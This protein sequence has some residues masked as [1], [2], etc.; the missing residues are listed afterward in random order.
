MNNITLEILQPYLD[1]GYKVIAVVEGKNPRMPANGFYESPNTVAYVDMIVNDPSITGFGIA[2][3]P[4]GTVFLDFDDMD[5]YQKSMK[6]V[7]E[8]L[9]Y[10][11]ELSGKGVHIGMKVDSVESIGSAKVAMIMDAGSGK[12]KCVIEVKGHHGYV[13]MAPSEHWGKDG[14]SGKFYQKLNGDMWDLPRITKTKWDEYVAALSTLNEVQLVNPAKVSSSTCY[15]PAEVED[16]YNEKVSIGAVLF[17]NGYTRDPYFANKYRHPH[18]ES[19][20]FGLVVNSNGKAY[21]FNANDV[22]H[23][24]RPHTAFDCM[25]ILECAGNWGTAYRQAEDELGIR[26][27]RLVPVDRTVKV[28]L[29]CED[30]NGTEVLCNG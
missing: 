17:R 15:T 11:S 9:S 20:Q 22:L 21:S 24:N 16:R 1:G 14:P 25:R 28:A 26:R 6:L 29:A 10:P 8:L 13:V 3:G 27:I 2:G 30:A 19:G 12:P 4:D 5:Y 7:P 18:S 23:D